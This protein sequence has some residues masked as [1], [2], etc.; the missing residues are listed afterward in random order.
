MSGIGLGLVALF[1]ALG[2]WTLLGGRL[3]SAP[4]AAAAGPAWYSDP[5]SLVLAL[6]TLFVIVDLALMIRQIRKHARRTRL[7]G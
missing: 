1:T 3:A 5:V 7:A 4:D 2:S 6:L